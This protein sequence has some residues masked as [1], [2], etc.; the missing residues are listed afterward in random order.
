MT[1]YQ[2]TERSK[3]K[4]AHERARYD[5][6]TV[7]A[8]FDAIPMCHVGYVI[9]G[10]PYVTPTTQWRVGSRLY[11]HG[12][13]ASRMIRA[14]GSGIP[15]CVTVSSFDGFVMARSPFHHSANYRSAMAF[16]QAH[17]ITDRDEME[18]SLRHMFE[19]LFAGR[20]QDIRGNTDKELKATKVVYMDIEE[21]SAK[22]RSGPPVDDEED[23]DG[24]DCWAGV[25]PLTH[26]FGAP[27]TDP[28]LR[29]GIAF[30][31]YLKHLSDKD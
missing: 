5:H 22:A 3:A 7:H 6:E 13:S 10:Q 9:D 16:G 30:P 8:M 21:A 28:R 12:S 4:R 24:V 20:W 1:S 27:E 26:R 19:H 2:P 31:D 15:V 23:Y 29:Q 18:E 25:L 11:W 14:T 17:M